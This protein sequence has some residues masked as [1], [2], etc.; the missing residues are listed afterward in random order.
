MALSVKV[1]SFTK[2]STG[3]DDATQDVSSIGFD[4]KALIMWSVQDCTS[5]VPAGER[6]TA[7]FS[8]GFCDDADV[9]HCCCSED[10]DFQARTAANT[11]MR[12]DAIIAFGQSNTPTGFDAYAACALGTDKFTLTWTLAD[13]IASIIKFIAYGGSDITGVDVGKFTINGSTGDQT[14]TTDSDTQSITDTEGIV[15]LIKG[16]TDTWNTGSADGSVN[17]GAAT[18][19]TKEH[20]VSIGNDDNSG[21]G[22]SHEWDDNVIM[23]QIRPTSQPGLTLCKFTFEEF[24]SSGFKINI[25]TIPTIGTQCGFLIIKGGDW[26]VGVSAAKTSTTG[27]VAVTTDF[28]PTGLFV[29]GSAAVTEETDKAADDGSGCM[30]AT[31]GTTEVWGNVHMNDGGNPTINVSRGCSSTGV[32][33]RHSKSGTSSTLEAE[34]TFDSFNATDFT[35]DWTTVHATEA[36]RFLW[37]VNSAG[38]AEVRKTYQGSPIPQPIF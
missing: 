34:G 7:M 38:T 8:W 25:S 37:V 12:D 36:Y 18:S 14:I 2:E 23:N 6:G 20:S 24:N 5:D 32:Y 16:M 21:S 22:E 15:F 31:D 3:V 19:A 35:L 10:V 1:G 28:Q 29:F 30:G 9:S 17:L 33:A 27:T 13:T 4:P 11:W 26:D